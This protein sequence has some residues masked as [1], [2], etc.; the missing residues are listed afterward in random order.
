MPAVIIRYN[1]TTYAPLSYTIR[2][3]LA[4]LRYRTTTTE[5]TAIQTDSLWL[6]IFTDPVTAQSPP[7]LIEEDKILYLFY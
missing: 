7:F 4:G 5:I 1:P 2:V 3:Y 6:L